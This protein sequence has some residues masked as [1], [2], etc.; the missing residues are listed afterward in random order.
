MVENLII[1]TT[2]IN[3]YHVYT[4]YIET[5]IRL[6]LLP[7]SITY[8]M[9][10]KFRRNSTSPQAIAAT[11]TVVSITLLATAQII[12]VKNRRRMPRKDILHHVQQGK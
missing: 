8:S 3:L 7:L 6:I 10:S 5:H 2:I 11:T 4:Y 9:R 1:M 12:V